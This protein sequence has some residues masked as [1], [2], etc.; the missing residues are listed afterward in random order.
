[1]GLKVFLSAFAVAFLAEM[2]DKTQ[3][4][5]IGLSASSRRPWAVAAGAAAALILVTA[6]AAFLGG[7][8]VRAVPEKILRRTAAVLFVLMGVWTWVRP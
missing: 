7:E 2:G 5:V 1:M 8:I 3:L 4:A 6:L